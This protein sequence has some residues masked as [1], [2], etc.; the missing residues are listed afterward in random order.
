VVG[1]ESYG[2]DGK[3]RRALEVR[4]QGYVLAVRSNE[5]PSTWPPSGMPGQKA[6]A[7]LGAAIPREG[8]QRHS[9]GEGAQGP[10]LYDWAYLP[11]RPALR[12]G[13][14]QALLL[15]R[16]PNRTQEVAYYL[17]YAPVA[18]PLE[19][20]V[21][22]A[23]ARWTIEEMFKLA[24]GQVGLDHYEVRSWEGWHRHIT[25]ALV[26]LAAL[27]VGAAK[28]G[29]CLARSTSPLPSRKSADSWSDSCGPQAI[30]QK[31][32]WIGPVG[33]ASIRRWLSDATAVA[34]RANK[35]NC[36]TKKPFGS[37]QDKLHDEVSGEGL[38]PPLQVLRFAQNGI[39]L[40]LLKLTSGRA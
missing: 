35:G 7:E 22:A 28:K 26:A 37:A 2:S 20:V 40:E 10:R 34:V 21:R 15:R 13:W 31:G 5:K 6:V 24:K 16:H 19:E 14:V 30:R 4:G 17:V 27:A 11:L 3:L 25:L 23:G 29:S 12:E 1:D 8:W 36:N 18:W 38:P 39:W 33:G 9:C 32:C